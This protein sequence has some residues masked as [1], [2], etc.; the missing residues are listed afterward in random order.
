[1]R[2]TLL[3]VM[4]LVCLSPLFARPT[5]VVKAE[6]ES[7][8]YAMLT[9]VVA[10]V[11]EQSLLSRM[12]GE[13]V[14]SISLSDLLE[15]EPNALSAT[16]LFSYGPRT[17]QLFLSAKGE[18]SKKLEKALEQ[19]LSSMLLYDGRALFESE[20]SLLVEYAYESGYATLSPL[21]IGDH[22]KG[23]DAQGNRW[24]TVVVRHVSNEENPVSLLVGTSG[25]ELL[26]GMR[27]EKQ[28]G[29]EISLSVSRA[30]TRGGQLAIEGFYSQEVG[31]YPFT[32]VMGG[33][34]DFTGSTLSGMNGQAGFV[35]QLPLSMIFGLHSG[36][37]RNSSLSMRCTLGLGYALSGAD[38]LYGS[39]ALFFYRYRLD[40]LGFDIGVGNKHWVTELGAYSS[41]LF[42][43]LGLAYTY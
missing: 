18:D 2:R 14:L 40:S 41:G 33:G 26:P 35:L 17:L 9:G 3:S 36:F 34:F 19:R 8:S 30:L 28:E 39:N 23:L 4:M 13:G 11:G 15:I 31:L 1:M 27:L 32:L 25:K 24:A 38:L 37:W 16:V 21:Q 7:P 22:Y 20:D 43:Q 12:D 29:R 6:A 5:L 10:R 42:M